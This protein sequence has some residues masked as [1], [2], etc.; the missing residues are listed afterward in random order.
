MSRGEVCYNVLVIE[1]EGRTPLFLANRK[2]YL[3]EKGDMYVVK[4]HNY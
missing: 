3:I 2:K 1:T 4:P